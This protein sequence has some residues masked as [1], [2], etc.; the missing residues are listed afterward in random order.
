MPD[1]VF[2]NAHHS[3]IGAFATFTLGYPGASGGFGIGLE[4][5]AGEPVYVGYEDEEGVYQALPFFEGAE[6]ETSRFTGRSSGEGET[7]KLRAIPREQVRRYLGA[8]TDTWVTPD[9]ELRIL[10]P[11]RSIPEPESA[12]E[13]ALKAVL[14][15]VVLAEVT[16]DNTRGQRTRNVFFGYAGSDRYSG[17][18]RL[19]H[20]MGRRFVGVGQGRETAI[21]TGDPDTRSGLGFDPLQIFE[22]AHEWNSDCMLGKVGLVVGAVPPG[23]KR[24]YQF[25][26]CFH[27]AGIVTTGLEGSYYYQRFFDNIESVAAFAIQHFEQYSAWAREADGRLMSPHLSADQRFLLAQSIHSYYGATQLLEVE[28]K[29]VWIVA[30]GEY[31]MMNTF[32]LT[33]DQLFY[34]LR[35]NPWTVKNVLDLY[36]ARYSY[37]DQVSFPSSKKRYEGGISFTHDMGVANQFSPPGRSS[38]ER[39][40]T[41][42]CFSHMT[43]EELVNWLLCALCYIKQSGDRSWRRENTERIRE[44]LESMGNRDH[45]D[46]A[47]R[48]GVMS[49]DSSRCAGESEI[50]T[51]DSLDPALGQARGNLYLAVKCWAAYLLLHNHYLETGDTGPAEEALGQALLAADTIA[52]AADENG[53]LPAILGEETAGKVI[54][55]IEGLVFPLVMGYRDALDPEG[56]FGKMLQV[57]EAHFRKVLV[58]GV[59]L[60]EDGGWKI[61]SASDNS[62]LSK[63]FLCQHVARKLFGLPHDSSADR[64]HVHWL[65][66]PESGFY[67]FSDQIHAGVAKGSRYYPRGVTS[68]LWLDE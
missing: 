6:D 65:V 37:T 56:P 15:P 39:A 1:R 24:T 21:V 44:C 61:S 57:L 8:A 46:R 30:E 52:S 10:S 48:D 50:T 36:S 49:L 60:F 28:G 58:P 35:M 14:A 25:A 3:P 13:E 32:D 2:Y 5:P 68:I 33:V 55:V 38:Y 27:R 19:D 7:Q 26:L 16:L 59:C 63:I 31:R 41:S 51:Y 4:H 12:G 67:A 54:P 22:P 62:W 9:F 40:G 29:P 34:E 53:L 66:R 23:E 45:P 20:T 64:A 43:H 11:V 47:K 17:M 42:E 18:R